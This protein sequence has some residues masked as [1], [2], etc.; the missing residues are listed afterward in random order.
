MPKPLRVKSGPEYWKLMERTARRVESWP[1]WKTGE[2]AIISL[3]EKKEKANLEKQNES[4]TPAK[5]PRR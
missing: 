3:P 1:E 4:G 5:I 2:P